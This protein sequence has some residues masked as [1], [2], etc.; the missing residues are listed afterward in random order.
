MRSP[1]QGPRE[2]APGGDAGAIRAQ[3]PTGRRLCLDPRGQS[4]VEFAITAPVVL[5][6]ILF[7]VDFGR[8]FLGWVTLTNAAREAANF[9][10]LNPYAWQ[11]PANAA[12]QTEFARLITAEAGGSNCSLPATPTP[13]FPSGTEIGSPVIVSITRRFS[14]IPPLISNLLGSSIPVSASASFPIRSGAIAGTPGGGVLP[15]VGPTAPPATPTQTPVPTSTPIPTPS[16]L[17]TA[18]PTCTV[19]NLVGVHAKS[20]PAIW[21]TSGFVTAHLAFQPLVGNG[22]PTITGQTLPAGSPQLCSAT[23]TAVN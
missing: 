1:G 22:N 2:R 15:T 10:S 16:Q 11:A 19:P 3:R 13:S 17:P 8:V 7:G 5:L 21:T 12:A 23:M 4:L 9:A 14:L 18:P 6:L 20:A